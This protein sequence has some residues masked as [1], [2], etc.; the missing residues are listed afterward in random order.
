MKKNTLSVLLFFFNILSYAQFSV[1]VSSSI[2][3]NRANYVEIILKS[4]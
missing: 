2:S 3:I 1:D 4:S